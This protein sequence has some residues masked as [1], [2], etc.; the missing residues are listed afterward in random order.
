MPGWFLFLAI[1]LWTSVV[2][3]GL[4]QPMCIFYGQA[5]DG[6]GW[7]YMNSATVILLRQ[8]TEVARCEI[9]GPLNPGVNFALRAYLDDNQST[10]LY[11]PQA[12]HS[13]DI[14]SIVVQDMYGLKTI[15]ESNAVPNVGK[16]GDI[17]LINVTAGT[18]T[19]GDGIPDEW[20]QEI[21]D[22]GENPAVSNLESVVGSDDYD[23][24]GQSNIDE[25]HAGTFAFLD[26]DY[27]YAEH[28]DLTDNGRLMVDFLS[29]PG[30][31]Y[32]AQYSTNVSAGIWLD[33]EYSE[34][35]TGEL[36]IGPTIGD[37]DWLQMYIPITETNRAF[38]LTVN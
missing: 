4:P 14:V 23:G 22:Y 9:S 5:L 12:V 37:G 28:M 32:A 31:V 21:I 36:S 3:A 7:P 29:V 1:V 2:C 38:R 20:E 16:P 11:T 10:N 13:G 8:T 17:L 25:Y 26:Y 18:D 33:C 24:D 34:T 30:K 15:M 19:D 35:E 27:F 6:Y